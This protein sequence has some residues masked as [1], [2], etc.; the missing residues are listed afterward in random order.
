MGTMKTMNF[1]TASWRRGAIEDGASSETVVIVQRRRRRNI[2]VAVAILALVAIAATILMMRGGDEGAAPAPAGKGKNAESAPSVTV[3]VPGR[4]Q[5]ARTISATGTLAARRD[6]PVGVAGE[7]GMVARVLVEP[8]QWV[9]AGQ[10][11]A[12]IERSVQSQ[13]AQQ[14]AASIDVARADARLAQQELERA[15][16]LVSR[17]FVSKADVERRTAARD[18]ANARV[19]VAQAQLAAARA[20]IGRLNIRAPAAGLVLD[21]NVEPGQV[22]SGGTGPLF[23]IAQGGQ[24]E[25]LAQLNEADLAELSVGVPV[26][27]TPVGTDQQVVGSVWQ[28]SP[29]IDPQTRQGTARV[30]IPYSRA[31]RPGGFANAEIR[32]GAVSAPVLPESAVLT[33][34]QGRYVYVVGNDNKVDRRPVRTGAVTPQGLTIVEGL[35]GTERV[36]AYAG[37]FLNPGEV[38]IPRRESADTPRSAR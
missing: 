23:R 25:L 11:L 8:G 27:V 5:V 12:V 24:M 9:G 33:D 35:N 26:T 34:Q 4:Q 32:A 38:V 28:I 18:A 7:G 37:G 29:V 19:R 20:R 1:E 14:L 13:E 21:R 30:A 36:V 10:T 3:V 17:G 31:I 2:I 6:M 15:Q 16:A 22:V